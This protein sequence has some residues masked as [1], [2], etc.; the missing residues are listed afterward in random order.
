MTRW[1]L[2]SQKQTNLKSSHFG[3][4]QEFKHLTFSDGS[5]FSRRM[6]APY[7]K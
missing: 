1:G 6:F 3:Q 7:K 2:S 5:T 4:W